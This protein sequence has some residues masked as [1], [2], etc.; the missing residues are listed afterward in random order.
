M[1][2][3]VFQFYNK[4]QFLLKGSEKVIFQSYQS[5][6]ALWEPYKQTLTLGVDWDYSH[7]T[8]KHLYMFINEYVT[9]KELNCYEFRTCKNKKAYIK[10]LID[11]DII[12]FD[13]WL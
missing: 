3:K 7:T 8:L 13:R 12:K 4:N 1:E 11:K 6:V 9:I 5:T 10:K 2:L